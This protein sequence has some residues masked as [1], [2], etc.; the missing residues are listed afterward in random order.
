[1][2]F[3]T[4]EPSA[5]GRARTILRAACRW[6]MLCGIALLVT[7]AWSVVQLD[8]GSSSQIRLRGRT[9]GISRARLGGR[10]VPQL[11]L[12]RAGRLVAP[13]AARLELA[14]AAS[15]AGRPVGPGTYQL[16][17]EIGA[18]QQ[19]QLVFEDA[20]R[21]PLVAWP[22]E[23]GIYDA[24]VLEPVFYLASQTRGEFEIGVFSLRWGAIQL[25]CEFQQLEESQQQLA[26]WRL[27]SYLLEASSEVRGRIPLGSLDQLVGVQHGWRLELA[28]DE[29]PPRL[30]CTSLVSARLVVRVNEVRSELENLPSAGT[31]SDARQRA[32]LEDRLRQLV[33]QVRNADA[34]PVPELVS[35][36]VDGKELRVSTR[37]VAAADGATLLEIAGPTGRLSYRLPK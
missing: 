23:V 10:S 20:Q 32:A 31:E 16:A 37:L 8:V 5:P 33:E 7:R 25:Q 27:T 2:V 29:R 22:L 28:G 14:G 17:L 3:R 35:S 12:S 21:T 24:P 30:K 34:A 13:G 4:N 15:S 1:M 19:V 11:D 36:S 9:Y 6:G 26:G 18:D